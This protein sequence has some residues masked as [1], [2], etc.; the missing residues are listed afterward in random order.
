MK[1]NLIYYIMTYVMYL[2]PPFIYFM[3]MINFDGISDQAQWMIGIIVNIFF[4]VATSLTLYILSHKNKIPKIEKDEKNHFIFGYIGN[5]VMFLYTYQYTMNIER[6]V[7]VFSLVL[8]LL[9]AY[10]LL[11]SQKISFKEILLFGIVFS[12]F[13]YIVIISSGNTL[14][15]D[16]ANFT[17]AESLIF[18]I[19]FILIFLFTIGYFSY[20]LYKNHKWSILRY[21]FISFL[22]LFLIT[23]YIDNISEEIFMTLLILALF[24]WIIEIILKLI[25]KE[26]IIQDLVF[27][28]RIILVTML[29]GFTKE[30]EL[31]ILP[32]FE[33]EQMGWLIGIFYV[34]A[35]SDILMQ[36]SPKVKTIFN[37][38]ISLQEYMKHLYKPITSRYKDILL[39]SDE[40]DLPIDLAHF[41]REVIQKNDNEMT[42]L[43]ETNA[44]SFI[45]IYTSQIELINK[46]INEYPKMPICVLSKKSLKQDILKTCFTNYSYYIYTI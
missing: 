28:A 29:I 6:V 26:F 37:P 40:S 3:V 17:N 36:I 13:D 18:Q 9:I 32:D 10:K 14:F 39:I 20:K 27:Y 21:V 2:Y 15:N 38:S 41:G 1:N 34:S 16:P 24:T 30:L 35:F 7:S 4:V 23:L 19:I 31:Y 8:L 43:I 11:V 45:L 46:T 22:S 42:D 25:H 33:I 5:I 12:V 44:V